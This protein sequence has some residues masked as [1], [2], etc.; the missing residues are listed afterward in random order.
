MGCRLAAYSHLISAVIDLNMTYVCQP[1]NWACGGHGYNL[2]GGIIGCSDT[3]LGNMVAL[4]TVQRMKTINITLKE[5]RSLRTR[6]HNVL[7]QIPR[8]DNCA[9]SGEGFRG[10]W[11]WYR[12][13]YHLVRLHDPH[14][15]TARCWTRPG[16]LKVAV[17]IRRGDDPKRGYPV[18]QYVRIL[19][20][21]FDDQIIDVHANARK[22]DIAVIAETP[23][24][25]P[26]MHA[27]LKYRKSSSVKF[28]LGAGCP[29]HFQEG[30]YN[31]MVADLDC[32]AT[33]DVL[34]ISHGSF[35]TLAVAVQQKGVSLVMKKDRR[36]EAPNIKSIPNFG[37]VRSLRSTDMPNEIDIMLDM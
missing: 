6:P 23:E 1:S 10:S 27:F 20:A 12:S 34:L 31:R 3:T 16:M 29:P 14:R 22:A 37:K 17:A 7:Y 11:M 30:C 19:D 35:S 4:K 36:F 5:L 15:Q 13:Q 32:M 9:G 8:M 33:S 25:D 24:D 26:E 28:F 2:C 18:A 21:L